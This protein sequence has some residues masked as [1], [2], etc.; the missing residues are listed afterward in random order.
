MKSTAI[1]QK[2]I[3]VK[4][5]KKL[6][7]NCDLMQKLSRGVYTS[8]KISRNA[9]RADYYYFFLNIRDKIIVWQF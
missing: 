1:Q 6:L 2:L 5:K 9:I 4:L 8:I 7:L 3:E